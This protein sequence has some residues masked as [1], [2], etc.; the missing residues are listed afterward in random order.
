M[1]RE[2]LDWNGLVRSIRGNRAG[3]ATYYKPVCVI[4][5]IDLANIGRLDS[6]L[7][8]SELIIRRF[9]EYVSAV[10]PD[11][12]GA[13]W[14]PLWFLANDGLWT[15]SKKGKRLTRQEIREGL[16]T[17]N[18][19]FARFDTQAIASDYQALWNNP[20]QRKVLRDQMLLI[21][22]RDPENRALLRTLFDPEAFGDPERWPADDEIDLRLQALTDQLKLFTVTESD[23]PEPRKVTREALLAF[24]S[25]GLP[26]ASAVGPIFEE[27]GRTPIR[28]TAAPGEGSPAQADFQVALAGKCQHLETLAA[29]TNRATHILPSLRGMIDALTTA[30]SQSTSY[31]VWSHGNTLRRLHDAEL[32]ALESDD[33]EAPPLPERLGELLGDVVEQFNV[34]AL[35]DPIVGLLDR[36]KSG[37]EKRSKSLRSLQAGVTLVAA[38]RRTPEIVDPEAALVLETATTSA[39]S[40]EDAPGFNTDQAIVNAVEIQRNGARAILVNALQEVRNVFT[41]AKGLGKVTVE[42]A[43]KQVGVEIVKQ[44]PI[45]AFVAGVQNLFIALWKGVA[46]SEQVQQLVSLI[47][48]L[49]SHLRT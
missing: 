19:A 17:K 49:I 36:A 21:L 23:G 27:T 46:G 34:Y 28:L 15:F 18:T 25:Q 8:H 43:A 38:I 39:Q 11:R 20:A 47:R 10:F 37:P 42:G 7:L 26:K 2:R 6:D 9:S 12:A 22:A 4:A 32:R 14:Q 1:V 29:A 35:T 31:L 24:D 44:L 16:S 33:P 13:G 40:A 41:K 30:P 3:K 45:A 48:D 5:A